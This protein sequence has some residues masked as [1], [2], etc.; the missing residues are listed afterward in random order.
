MPRNE[1]VGDEVQ[2]H[3]RSILLVFGP[4]VVGYFLTFLYR[5]INSLIAPSLSSEF[6]LSAASLGLLTSTFFLTFAAAQLPLGML[7]DRH[8][9]RRVQTLLLPVAAVGALLFA[10]AQS[11]AVLALGRALL[12]VGMAGALT[13]GLKAIV[14]CFPKE[15]LALANGWFVMI[16]ALGAVSAT[17]PAEWLLQSIGWRGLFVTLAG[18]TAAGALLV[19]L[20]VPEL[21]REG[22]ASKDPQGFDLKAVLSDRRFW[23]IAPLAA[24]SIGTSWA[25]HG[26]WAASWLADVETLGRSDVVRHLFIMAIALSPAALLLGLGADR[27]RRN[28]MSLPSMLGCTVLLFVI[29]QIALVL[30]WPLP[31]CLLWVIVSGFGTATVLNYALLAEHYP[32][33]VAG[34]AN[35]ALN[36][37]Q[38]GGALVTQFTTGAII[39]L[40]ASENGHYPVIAYQAAFSFNIA[41]QIGSLMWFAWPQ[42]RTRSRCE[43]ELKQ[44]QRFRPNLAF[45]VERHRNALRAWNNH[46]CRA[47]AQLRCWR[48]AGLASAAIVTLLGTGLLA[49]GVRSAVTPYVLQVDH[50]PD[51]IGGAR[52]NLIR[53]SAR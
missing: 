51:Q 31:P 3:R 24:T 11:V 44:H 33:E 29:A 28:G 20:A 26:L 35:A 15:R 1:V 21:Q 47:H 14:E 40:W 10:N 9:P 23:R 52:L 42:P 30:R 4:F 45:T 41:L 36:V 46:L 18:T 27:L 25:L 39:E 5:S 38:L 49:G 12:G 7:L 53:A 48:L 16:G 34:R 32:K 50:L 13:A 6:N 17:T 43:L 19:H 37:F 2:N 8:G 22:A